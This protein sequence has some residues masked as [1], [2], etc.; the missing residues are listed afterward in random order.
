MKAKSNVKYNHT[1]I[2]TVCYSIH[3]LYVLHIRLLYSELFLSWVLIFI[4]VMVSLQV[5]KISNHKFFHL[6]D[7]H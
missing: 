1:I 6:H 5:M 7:R 2:T 4:T 3:G